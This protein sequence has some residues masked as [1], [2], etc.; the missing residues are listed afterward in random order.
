ML[1]RSHC[2]IA[3]AVLFLTV[4]GARADVTYCYQG[5]NFNQNITGPYT[6]SDAVSGCVTLSAALPFDSPLTYYYPSRGNPVV[7]SP[8]VVS[9][10]LTDGVQSLGIT[11]T[12]YLIFAFQTTDGEIMTWDVNLYNN[13]INPQFSDDIETINAPGLSSQVSDTTE[14]NSGIAAEGGGGASTLSDPG[15]WTR[16]PEQG[17]ISLS[18][19]IMAAVVL[20]SKRYAT[21]VADSRSRGRRSP[22]NI[23]LR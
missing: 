14:F 7:T 4:A 21:S 10:Y 23:R 13:P 16:V 3:L 8:E 9:A 5:N 22:A 17:P 19:T 2:M 6:T 12:Q 15:T 11:V 1:G 18:L 20:I